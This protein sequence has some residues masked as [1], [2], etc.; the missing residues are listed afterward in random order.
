MD[1]ESRYNERGEGTLFFVLKQNI[2]S[3]MRNNAERI[4]GRIDGKVKGKL[5]LEHVTSDWQ[6]S[7][8][9]L[10]KIN[11]QDHQKRAK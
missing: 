9:S 10:D 2:L 1:K 6:T 4:Y 5:G 11:N 3:I 8:Y 7:L